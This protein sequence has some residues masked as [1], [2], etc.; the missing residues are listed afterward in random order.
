MPEIKFR[1]WDTEAELWRY[2]TLADAIAGKM[3][4]FANCLKNPELL[5][6]PRVPTD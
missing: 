3:L 5:F 6:P 2:F 1:A 4:P